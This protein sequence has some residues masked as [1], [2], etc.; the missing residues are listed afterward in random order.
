[1]SAVDL[2]GRTPGSFEVGRKVLSVIRDTASV[3]L[4]ARIDGKDDRSIR[5][6]YPRLTEQPK[7]QERG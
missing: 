4:L 1:M 2:S 6:I 7:T 5:V 3:R